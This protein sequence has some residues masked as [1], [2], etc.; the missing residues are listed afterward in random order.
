MKSGQGR[1]KHNDGWVYEGEYLEDKKCGQGTLTDPK[2][3]V[4]YVGK[5]KDNLPNG[6]GKQ[7]NK[8][9]ELIE[10]TFINGI[11]SQ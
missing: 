11:D 9:H 10:S 1:F 5:W 6:V 4:K 8:K 7:A 2:G 3:H